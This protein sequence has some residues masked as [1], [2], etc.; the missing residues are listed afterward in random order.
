MQQQQQHQG[1]LQGSVVK[2]GLCGLALWHWP[3]IK[4]SA[5][6]HGPTTAVLQSLCHSLSTYRQVLLST[7][8]PPCMHA[9]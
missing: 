9:H 4:V 5:L 8:R 3:C 6:C 7:Y 2:R 1:R